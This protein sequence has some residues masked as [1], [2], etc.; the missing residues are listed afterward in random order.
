[1]Q[2]EQAELE[3]TQAARWRTQS[4]IFHPAQN[5]DWSSKYTA[6]KDRKIG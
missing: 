6:M 5:I 3:T 2:R 4:Q 1:M